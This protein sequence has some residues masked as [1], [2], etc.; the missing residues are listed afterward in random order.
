MTKEQFL[1]IL[2][3]Y[4]VKYIE[5]KP[6]DDWDYYQIYVEDRRARELKNSNPEKYKDVYVPYIRVSHFDGCEKYGFETRVGFLY[7]RENGYTTWMKEREV[8]K[9]CREYGT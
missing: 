3:D 8:I 6:R 5:V 2:D 1:K 9:R 4:K 7:T